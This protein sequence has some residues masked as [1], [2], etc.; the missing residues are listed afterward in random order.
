MSLIK[1]VSRRFAG[2]ILFFA[3]CVRIILS[4]AKPVSA[5]VATPEFGRR[6]GNVSQTLLL[7]LPG[8]R[9]ITDPRH[10]RALEIGGEF[11]YMRMSSVSLHALPVPLLSAQLITELP[12]LRPLLIAPI[13][14]LHLSDSCESGSCGS[15]W[16][17]TSVV[18]S[19]GG[20]GGGSCGSSCGGGG[21]FDCSW[22]Y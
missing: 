3:S 21:G 9:G 16:S 4:V 15:C 6:R 20:G 7:R 1:G 13:T 17:C 8:L 2:C 18:C 14:T 22:G 5:S 19:G 10:R 12:D 11:P